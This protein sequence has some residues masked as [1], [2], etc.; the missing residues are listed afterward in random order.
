MNSEVYYEISSVTL[1]NAYID[2]YYVYYWNDTNVFL[3]S[4][5]SEGCKVTYESDYL[6][7]FIVV[8]PTANDSYVNFTISNYNSSTHSSSNICSG[9]SNGEVYGSFTPEFSISTSSESDSKSFPKAAIIAIVLV[10]FLI[11]SFPIFIIS[12]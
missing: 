6:D 5:T 7:M 12:I 3:S 10:I 9:T 11:F 1:H 8:I 2:L 4:L